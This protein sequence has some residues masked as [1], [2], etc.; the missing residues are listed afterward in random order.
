M[1]EKQR[2]K[3]G[4]PSTCNRCLWSETGCCSAHQDEYESYDPVASLG[5]TPRRDPS[6]PRPFD[7]GHGNQN[8]VRWYDAFSGDRTA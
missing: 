4:R 5:K 3:P 8:R 7:F 2:R 6:E 1:A